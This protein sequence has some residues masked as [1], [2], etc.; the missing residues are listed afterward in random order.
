MLRRAEGAEIQPVVFMLDSLEHRVAL[1]RALPVRARAAALDATIAIAS[2][3]MERERLAVEL[4]ELAIRPGLRPK[5]GPWARRSAYLRQ[6]HADSALSQLCAHW[7]PLPIEI[8]SHTIAVASGRWTTVV[9]DLRHDDRAEARAAL[10]GLALAS[11]DPALF[12]PLAD[13]LEDDEPQI[14]RSAGQ[15]LLALATRELAIDPSSLAPD[16]AAC[17]DECLAH[18]RVGEPREALLRVL[19]TAIAR[20]SEHQQ[21]SVALACLLFVAHDPRASSLASTRVDHA[22]T[23]ALRGVL[24]WSRSPISRVSALRLLNHEALHDAAVSRLSRAHDLADHDL[25]LRQGHLTLHPSRRDPLGKIEVRVRST[26]IAPDGEGTPRVRLTMPKEAALPDGSWLGSLSEEAR[27]QI[28]RWLSAFDT[29]ETTTRALLDPLLADDDDI[30]RLLASQRANERT[31]TDFCFDRSGPVARSA[32]TRFSLHGA[33][34]DPSGPIHRRHLD[35]LSKLVRSPHAPVRRMAREDIAR[36]DPWGS[37]G[38]QTALI[39]RRRM[40]DEPEAF[41]VDLRHVLMSAPPLTRIGAIAIARRLAITE[42]IES[43]LISLITHAHGPAVDERVVASAISA[44]G[45][46]TTQNARRTVRM[47]LRHPDARARANAVEAM[48]RQER[49]A[50]QTDA[51]LRSTLTELRGDPNQRVR[52]NAVRSLM[53]LPEPKG[54]AALYTPSAGSALIAMLRDERAAHRVSGLWVAERASKAPDSALVGHI[55]SL[56]EMDPDRGVRT[57]AAGV[58][59]RIQVRRGLLGSTL[60]RAGADNAGADNRGEKAG[61]P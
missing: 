14:Q 16:L 7:A 59:H 34:H 11:A 38:P 19:R 41:L 36:L 40:A 35:T 32:M 8:R 2:D 23:Q 18:E 43:L 24:R 60:S 20:Y 44:L 55:Q 58:I 10:C 27:R 30:A 29:D 3:P 15:T 50:G 1:I 21:R 39:A 17:E 48:A 28:P 49:S 26:P 52:A 31:L 56:A 47:V 46:L 25:T 22:A 51:N 12:A 45:T 33:A 57:R 6:T 4:L 42:R 9:R 53:A 54:G 37:A 13:L 5:A 61:R